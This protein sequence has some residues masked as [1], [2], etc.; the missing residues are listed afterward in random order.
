MCSQIGITTPSDLFYV[1]N[2]RC[3]AKVLISLSL[4]LSCKSFEW[5]KLLR[6][7]ENV[8][9][10]IS[11]LRALT[12]PTEG[13]QLTTDFST[14]ENRQRLSPNPTTISNR[15]QRRFHQIKKGTR[16]PPSGLLIPYIKQYPHCTMI[17]ST[18][19]A[20]KY[21][22]IPQTGIFRL[23]RDCA[24]GDAVEGS[25]SLSLRVIHTYR[26]FRR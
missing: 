19:L 21:T 8:L 1:G 9:N 4:R 12:F 20:T 14:T 13:R 25:L 2:K 24:A 7:R 10:H 15:Q 6:I 3:Y 18:E 16:K 23:E 17:G 22:P 5:K 11:S 26:C